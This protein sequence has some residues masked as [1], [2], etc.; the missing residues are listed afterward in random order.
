MELIWIQGLLLAYRLRG[1]FA[2][3]RR[4]RKVD[5]AAGPVPGYR[6]AIAASHSLEPPQDEK[7]CG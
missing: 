7:P 3:Q 1:C 5:N 4:I 2:I 6:P